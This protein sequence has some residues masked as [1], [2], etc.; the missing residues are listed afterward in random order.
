MANKLIYSILAFLAIWFFG[1]QYLF[2]SI[3]G[4]ALFVSTIF[5]MA[6]VAWLSGGK[7]PI[8]PANKQMSMKVAI[9]T[10]IAAF[11]IGGFAAWGFP[12]FVDINALGTQP[13]TTVQTTTP[14]PI[15]TTLSGACA[16]MNIYPDRIG[17]SGTV[18]LLAKD[19]ENNDPQTK[20]DF[21]NDAR[22][23]VE[24]VERTLT[25]TS[26]GATFT[27]KVGES[28]VLYG[29]NATIYIDKTEGCISGNVMS[30][31]VSVHTVEAIGDLAIT[32]Y[33]SSGTELSSGTT[34]GEE[35]YDITLGA[36][37]EAVFSCKQKVGTADAS[38]NMLA[39]GILAGNDIDD[40]DLNAYKDSTCQ[41][42]HT[43]CQ[44]A[45]SVGFA[46]VPVPK[47]L[48]NI[49]I[50]NQS[51]TGDSMVNFSSYDKAYQLDTPILLRE[52][53]E[54]E[55]QFTI[56]AGST[57]PATNEKFG[58]SDVGI[59]CYFDGIWDQGSDGNEY[60][61]WYTKDT[62]ENNVGLTEDFLKPV[63]KDACVVI[64]GL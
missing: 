50:S 42:G 39:I 23:Y 21:L 38:F 36:N 7:V 1:A 12:G 57:N 58:N 47:F 20:G 26:T 19:K 63:G 32:C 8:F 6:T 18:T 28:W 49:E 15:M 27:G 56:T 2:G 35:D 13:A 22:V 33:D 52:F 10:G 29:G 9:F 62:S 37:E 17:E 61:T 51:G 4:I 34:S 53:D 3:T 30:N 16:G 48:R 5:V 55:H 64:E 43:S 45:S 31:D 44:T 11:A 46:Q 60:M 25:Q 41:S 54:V 14:T 59:I 24:G 40:V